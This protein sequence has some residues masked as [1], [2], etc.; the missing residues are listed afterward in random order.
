MKDGMKGVL[1]LMDG[2]KVTAYTPVPL[3]EPSRQQLSPLSH[4]A[5]ILCCNYSGGLGA[6]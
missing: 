4:F 3:K 1:Q 5:F 6:L 2:Q